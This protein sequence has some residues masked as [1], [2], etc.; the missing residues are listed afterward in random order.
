MVVVLNVRSE[1]IFGS[2][3]RTQGLTYILTSSRAVGVPIN[4]ARPLNS[5]RTGLR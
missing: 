2:P 5:I 3:I 4:H 1:N